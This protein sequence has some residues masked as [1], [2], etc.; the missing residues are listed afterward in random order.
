MIEFVE[1]K[2]SRHF[3]REKKFA[4]P[5][6][7][8]ESVEG[9]AGCFKKNIQ[10]AFT[11]PRGAF[12]LSQVTR[13]CLFHCTLRACDFGSSLASESQVGRAEYRVRL[14]EASSVKLE[15]VVQQKK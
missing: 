9:S 8:T 4:S 14:L 10:R 2:V 3:Y 15:P 13:G 7:S 5:K 1:L 6:K 12:S 11:A